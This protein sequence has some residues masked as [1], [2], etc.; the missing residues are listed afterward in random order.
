[1]AHRPKTLIRLGRRGSVRVSNSDLLAATDDEDVGAQLSESR[2]DAP[3]DPTGPACD[4]KGLTAKQ[5]S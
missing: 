5:L 4:K 2:R 1:M 3:I